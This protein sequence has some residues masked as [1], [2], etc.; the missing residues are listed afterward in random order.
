MNNS[1]CFK[2]V[3]PQGSIKYEDSE[4]KQASTAVKGSELSHYFS[5]QFYS[6]KTARCVSVVTLYQ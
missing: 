1:E 2:D 4:T 3:F 5:M 6:T